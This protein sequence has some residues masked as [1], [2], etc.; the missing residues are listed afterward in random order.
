MW[1]VP[2]DRRL[3][4]HA[5][6]FFIALTIA[7]TSTSASSPSKLRL[8]IHVV[9]LVAVVVLFVDLAFLCELIMLCWD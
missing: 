4:V 6:S 8:G 1:S 5:R 3:L 7:W 9:V 2:V